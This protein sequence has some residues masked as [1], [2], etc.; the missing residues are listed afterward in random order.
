MGALAADARALGHYK[1]RGGPVTMMPRRSTLCLFAWMASVGCA[2]VY[3]VTAE[4]SSS[5]SWMLPDLTDSLTPGTAREVLAQISYGLAGVSPIIHIRDDGTRTVGEAWDWVNRYANPDADEAAYVRRRRRELA[6]H[7]GCTRYRLSVHEAACRLPYPRGEPN[8][9]AVLRRLDSL[10]ATPPR[11][12]S[13]AASAS[14]Q[15][16]RSASPD[17]ATDHIVG[18]MDCSGWT[19]EQRDRGGYRK[20]TSTN[21]QLGPGRPEWDAAVAELLTAVLRQALVHAPSAN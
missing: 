4:R 15:V 20:V 18:C 21:Y 3:P 14:N 19:I 12:S 8:W 1:L 6:Q 13:A 11:M 10:L 5:L 2:R 17:R 16:A 9:R 7:F